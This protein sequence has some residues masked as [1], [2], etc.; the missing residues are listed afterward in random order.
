M[1]T[2]DTT[3]LQYHEEGRPGK[4]EVVPTKPTSSQLDLSLAYSPGVAAPVRAIAD[5]P[6]DVYRYTA[7]GNLVAVISNGT[8]I[9][10]LGNR[11]PLAA[12]PVMEGK[13]VLFKRF[14]D[15]DV[16]DIEVNETDPDKFIEVVRAI[17]PTFGGINLEDIK[18]PECFYIEETLKGML[19]IPVFHDDQHGTAIIATAGLLNA[20]Q[21][22]EKEIAD[23][24]IV[25]N[26]AGAAAV[27]CAELM[28][29]AGALRSNIT[30]L[31]SKGVI[32]AGRTVKMNEYKA[33]FA[34]ETEAR[35]LADALQGADA[36]FGLSVPDVVTPEMV[37]SMADTP[38]IFAM[39]NPDPEIKYDLAK[40][41]RP[42]V[43][44]ATGRSDFPNQA[45]NVL[46]FPF[47]FRGALD[48]QA[49]EINDAMKL[50]A[51]H[52]LAK[53]THEDVPDSVLKAYGLE[54]LKFGPDY[55]IPK[56]FD[57]RALLWV[58][59]AIA[60]AAMESGV[61]RKQIDLEAYRQKLEASLGKGRELMRGIISRA[62]KQP[63]RVVF[64][65]GKQ[66]RIIRAAAI[67][68]EEGIAEP[69]LLG[70]TEIIQQR[71]AELGLTFE[72]EIIEPRFSDK[73]A[74]YSQALFEKRCY[75]GMTLY[76]AKS[77]LQMRRYFGPM[78]VEM[79]DAD[80]YISGL[81]YN[82]GDVLRP[83]LEVIGAEP[84]VRRVAG[85][86]IIIVRNQPYFFVDTTVNVEPTAEDLAE[87]ASMA[88]DR[89]RRFNIEPRIAMLSFSN[90]GS[91]RHPA[92]RKM[93]RAVEILHQNRPDLVVDG[94]MMVDTALNAT[95]ADD[96]YPFSQVRNANILVFPHLEAAN[97]GYKLVR[98]LSVAEFIGPIMMGFNKPIHILPGAD[99]EVRDIVN[100]SA[101]AVIDAQEQTQ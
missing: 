48:V 7:K 12:K 11:G 13:G 45:N 17:A 86:D 90:F 66:Y 56:P 6:D 94:E 78:M 83:S 46:G 15:V 73:Y 26:G 57:P 50:A 68:A 58:A 63:K 20:L 19:D 18:A 47:I 89:V 69:I 14:A 9:L 10:G 75:K 36:F 67:I 37:L 87:I 95:L 81:T 8:A 71:I 34:I 84:A 93:R 38:I 91:N 5:D 43:I 64:G 92:A 42:E 28:I 61:A 22:A 27:A 98:E 88:A 52:A 80:A 97:I 41:T 99:V 54:T 31:D 25:I 96:I 23:L 39:A 32:Y 33:R 16:F 21:L 79:G 70:R 100:L 82:Y 85:M 76:E 40:S 30:M 35:T 3:A 44:M 65:E 24:K 60:K 49:R 4:I 59:P 2:N 77:R 74:S 101:M 53:L 72:P 29:L 62:K 51:V 1:S 55:I